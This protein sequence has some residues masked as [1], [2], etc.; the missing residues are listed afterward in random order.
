M[1]KTEPVLGHIALIEEWHEDWHMGEDIMKNG[2]DLHE[3]LSIFL[4]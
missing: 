3:I 4:C 1:M 2:E